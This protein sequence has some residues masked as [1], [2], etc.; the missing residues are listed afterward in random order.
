MTKS[1]LIF[2][3]EGNCLFWP[4]LVKGSRKVNIRD[5]EK[6]NE[7]HR[8][9]RRG[10]RELFMELRHKFYYIHSSVQMENKLF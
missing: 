9:V 7:D 10:G 4:I 3:V 1:C 8:E 5:F 6:F 2:L